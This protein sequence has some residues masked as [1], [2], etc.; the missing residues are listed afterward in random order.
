[1]FWKLSPG[2][3]VCRVLVIREQFAKKKIPQC[4][5]DYDAP[6]ALSRF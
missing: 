2:K 6:M 4:E 3:N 5:A 1:V